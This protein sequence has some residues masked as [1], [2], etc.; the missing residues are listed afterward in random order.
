MEKVIKDFEGYEPY[1]RN[2]PSIT[3]ISR[4]YLDVLDLLRKKKP[5]KPTT[6]SIRRF[7]CGSCEEIIGKGQRY[8]G[9]CGLEVNWD[10]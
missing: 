3:M 7:R 9:K 4:H 10:A 6:D 5:I 8:C 1:A 2:L